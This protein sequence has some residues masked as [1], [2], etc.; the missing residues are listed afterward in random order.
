MTFIAASFSSQPPQE[1]S[2]WM[3]L[4]AASERPILVSSSKGLSGGGRG[5]SEGAEGEPGAGPDFTTVVV[6]LDMASTSSPP[7]SA[8]MATPS[9]PLWDLGGNHVV[10]RGGEHVVTTVVTTSSPGFLSLVASHVASCL[11]GFGSNSTPSS[12]GSRG[13][14][15]RTGRWRLPWRYNQALSA[16]NEGPCPCRLRRGIRGCGA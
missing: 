5:G 1:G 15:A 12:V 16:A 11:N 9:S 14:Q 7:L 3:P 8:C 10:T 2:M 13:L 4:F 6:I